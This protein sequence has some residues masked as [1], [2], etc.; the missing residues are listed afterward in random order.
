VPEETLVREWSILARVETLAQRQILVRELTPVRRQ[1]P[2][3]GET[4]VREWSILARVETLAQL[5]IL[6]RELTPVRQQIL[7]RELTPVRRQTP[8][9]ELTPVLPATK[10]F[11]PN[12]HADTNYHHP[13]THGRSTCSRAA[14]VGLLSL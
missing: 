11:K 12:H 13:S 9:R 7:A 2:V 14:G 4:L 10:G 6:V 3:P 8:V 5:Q 1:T